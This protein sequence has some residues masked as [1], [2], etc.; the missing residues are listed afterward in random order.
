LSFTSFM[1]VEGFRSAGN[2]GERSP[3]LMLNGDVTEMEF[4]VL[5]SR[6]AKHPRRETVVIQAVLEAAEALGANR[7]V[8]RR[9]NN[10]STGVYLKDGE[11]KS[12]LYNDWNKDWGWR[13]IYKDMMATIGF[14]KN[15]SQQNKFT[16]TT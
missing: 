13:R 5:A 7:I 10:Y 2:V 4:I 11:K 12:L 14:P 16:L 9:G 3:Q 15:F 1:R 8:L 6:Y